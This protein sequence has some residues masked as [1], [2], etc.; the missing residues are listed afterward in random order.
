MGISACVLLLATYMVVD[1]TFI[2]II[3]TISTIY[4][5]FNSVFG[6]IG[7]WI[8]YKSISKYN[9]E[10]L[11]D[12]SFKANFDGGASIEINTDLANDF[13]GSVSYGFLVLSTSWWLFS[14]GW[15]VESLCMIA[16]NIIFWIMLKTMYE[17]SKSILKH[18][19]ESKR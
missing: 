7:L 12:N 10:L 17:Y 18:L 9:L 16:F 11:D 15:T 2:H 19:K 5:L 1:N 13:W 8:M 14:A 4:L 6:S 3:V